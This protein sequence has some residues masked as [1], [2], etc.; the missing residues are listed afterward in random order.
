MFRS[1]GVFAVCFFMGGC[2]VSSGG[3]GLSSS[4][5]SSF[6]A[7]DV[8][9][10]PEATPASSSGGSSVLS[11]VWDNFSASFRSGLQPVADKKT[12][13][14]QVDAEAALRLINDYRAAKGLRPLSLEPRATKAAKA[15]SEDMARNDKISHYGPN[16]ADVSQRLASAGY[17]YRLAAENVGVGQQN[18]KEMIDGW[19]SSPPHSKNMLLPGA[20]HMGIAMEYRPTGKYKTY[21]TLVLAAP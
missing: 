12:T 9:P 8:K 11:N 19:K 20:K 3:G 17:T 15:L 7:S 13:V 2:A 5:L 16:G 10:E 18:L 6:N 4:P 21:W 14:S 1:L